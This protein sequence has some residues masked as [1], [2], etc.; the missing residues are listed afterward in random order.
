MILAQVTFFHPDFVQ[1]S[2]KKGVKSALSP[3]IE[4]QYEVQR[5]T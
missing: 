2:G 3:P 4:P 5:N 1:I